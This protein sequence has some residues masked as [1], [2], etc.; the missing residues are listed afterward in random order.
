MADVNRRIARLDGRLGV[1]YL[2]IGAVFLTANGTITREVMYDFLHPTARGYQ[3]W[4][5]AM[6]P[7]L[8]RLSTR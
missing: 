3:L 1:T 2:D 8:E 6:A 7:T 5:E 4:W